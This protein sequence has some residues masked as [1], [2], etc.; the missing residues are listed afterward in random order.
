M[1]K[2]VTRR[3]FGRGLANGRD[4]YDFSKSKCHV[5]RYH[6]GVPKEARSSIQDKFLASTIPLLVIAGT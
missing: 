6:A 5:Y 4:L 1:V 2:K 3:Q